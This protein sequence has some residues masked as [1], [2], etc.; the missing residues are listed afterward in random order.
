MTQTKDGVTAL[1]WASLNGHVAVVKEPLN[2][3]AEVMRE[4]NY[5]WTA[6]HWASW[7]GGEGAAGR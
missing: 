3:K 5:G 4:D 6:L 2:G 7:N 1:H